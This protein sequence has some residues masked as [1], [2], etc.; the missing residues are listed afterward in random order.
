MAK[1]LI[2]G[3]GYI[4]QPLAKFLVSKGNEIVAISRTN[5]H[6]TTGV[7]TI[8]SDIHDLDSL[9]DVDAVIYLISADAHNEEMYRKAYIEGPKKFGPSSREKNHI[10]LFASSTSVYPF[11]DGR[12]VDEKTS[13]PEPHYFS[14]K[15]L[16]EAEKVIETFDCHSVSMRLGGIYGP[17]RY[18]LFKSIKIWSFTTHRPSCV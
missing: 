12:W 3:Y 5:K 1:I 9:P 16:Q 13:L 2:V 10:A 7:T 18:Y 17:N 6:Y 11:D 15:I 4:G 14:G 8:K